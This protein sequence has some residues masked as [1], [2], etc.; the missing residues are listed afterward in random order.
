MAGHGHARFASWR[1]MVL[2]MV[3]LWPGVGA[4]QTKKKKSKVVLPPPPQS[5]LFNESL[6]KAKAA[7]QPL[8]VFGTS[9]TCSRCIALK[10]A[11]AKHDELQQ[12]LSQYVSVEVTFGGQDFVAMYREIVRQK[13]EFREAIGGPS[14]FLF[15]SKGEAVYAGPNHANGMAADDTFKQLL[16]DGIAKN[17]PAKNEAAKKPATTEP[18]STAANSSKPVGDEVRVWKSASGHST[19][20]TLVQFD[21]KTVELKRE[22][23][24]TVKV[25]VDL[26]SEEDREYLQTMKP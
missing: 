21:G 8:V 20:A 17:G 7:G 22:D 25:D 13:P 18:V 5:A 6:A 15:T 14:V 2:A 24:R 16:I 4:G 1:L 26:L 19:S 9:E 12:L 11:L 23:G 3:L 10:Q